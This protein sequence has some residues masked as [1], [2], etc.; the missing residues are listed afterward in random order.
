MPE[1]I[2]KYLD[3]LKEF[4]ES[5]D[6]SQKTRFYITSAIVVIAVTISIIVLTRPQKITLFTSSDK[7]QIGEMINILN[8]NGIWNEAGNDGTSIII[9][10]KNNNKAQIVL[11][12]SGYPK[13]G[14]TFA[15]AISS[16]GLTTTQQDREQ[17]WMHQK[18]SDLETKLEM[19][20][21]IEE[22]AVTLAVPEKSI[23]LNASNEQPR[24]TA[25]VMVRPREKLSQT[26]VQGIVMLV[27]RSVENLDPKDVTVVDNN[28]NILNANYEDDSIGAVSSQEELRR[29]KE[30]ELQQKVLD[31]FSVGQFDSFDTLRVVANVVLDFDKEKSQIKRITN[32]EGMDGGAVISSSISE[33]IVKNAEGGGEPGLDS[34]PGGVTTYQIGEEGASE[35]SNRQEDINYGYDEVLSETEKAAG[36]MIPEESGLALSLWYGQKVTDDSRLSDEFISELRTALS[37]ATGI[38][39]RNISIS[40]FKLAPLETVEKTTADKIRELI[41][42]YGFFALMLLLIIGMLIFGIPRRK[43][44]GE[45]AVAQAASGPRFVVPEE[46]EPLPEIELEERSEIKKQIEKFVKQKPDAVA[47]LLRNWLS[48]D[49]DT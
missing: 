49:W 34:N 10:K 18:I 24:P 20:D 45:P 4:W 12:Q 5:L 33:E 7:K 48:E 22:A 16:I 2:K 29:K 43:E 6:K 46:E 42:D 37:T 27:S 25:Y 41:N 36:K 9:D 1:S 19:L 13:E 38:P 31:Y 44:T 23:F 21:N 40:K 3:Q 28:S 30:L 32:P 14:F 47:Q 26:Q 39:A 17:I 8:E 11:A 35:Y 15:D